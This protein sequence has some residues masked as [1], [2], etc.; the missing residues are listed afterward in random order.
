M[1]K[2]VWTSS[3]KLCPAIDS[4]GRRSIAQKLAATSVIFFLS[5]V[6]ETPFVANTFIAPLFYLSALRHLWS[7]MVL[8]PVVLLNVYIFLQLKHAAYSQS[9]PC[10]STMP[11]FF[12]RV[13]I[14]PAW[15]LR[16]ENIRSTSFGNVF[17]S[18]FLITCAF[19]K[20]ELDGTI[21]I[22]TSHSLVYAKFVFC[23]DDICTRWLRCWKIKRK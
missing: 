23:L 20:L 17:F 11:N 10:C 4:N 8:V 12:Q 7:L 14:K 5:C 3:F 16:I 19:S 15:F 18:S 13:E 1:S 22:S 21:S 2:I 9:L 6:V